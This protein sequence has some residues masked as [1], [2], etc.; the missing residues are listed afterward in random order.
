VPQGKYESKQEK[1]LRQETE[2]GQAIQGGRDHLYQQ[3][4]PSHLRHP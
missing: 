2:R 4:S 1:L 3:A